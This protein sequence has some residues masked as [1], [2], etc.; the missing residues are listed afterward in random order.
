M[1][2]ILIIFYGINII[3]RYFDLCDVGYKTLYISRHLCLVFDKVDDYVKKC[4]KTKY[5]A[6]QSENIRDYLLESDI[7]PR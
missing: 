1:I 2:L 5:Q 4:G 3:R 6:L 7:L